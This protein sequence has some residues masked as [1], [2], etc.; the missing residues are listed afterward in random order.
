MKPSRYCHEV[1]DELREGA[2]GAEGQ[3]K[4]VVL[5]YFADLNPSERDFASRLRL[6]AESSERSGRHS[7][8]SAARAVL[9]DWETRRVATAGASS[10]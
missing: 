7:L 3:Q 10:Q 5:A 4:I 6:L 1:I 2:A 9:D 8:A